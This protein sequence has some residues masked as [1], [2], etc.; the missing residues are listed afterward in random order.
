MEIVV[1]LALFVLASVFCFSSI[2]LIIM[3]RRRAHARKCLRSAMESLRFTK[4]NSENVAS[5]VQ[6]EPL[7]GYFY[8]FI[9]FSYFLVFICMHVLERPHKQA[10]LCSAKFDE[11]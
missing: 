11:T 3:C 1:Y 7:I 6:L 4:L 2:I 5:V 8:F 9:R 10:V